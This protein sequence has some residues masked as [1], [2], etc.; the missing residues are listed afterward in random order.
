MMRSGTISDLPSIDAMNVFSGSRSEEIEEER[1][2][3]FELDSAVVGFIV[4][5]RKG[6]L[7]RP[8]IEYLAVS[9]EFRRCN[10]ASR[11]LEY[12]EAKH[13]KDR[14]F[15]STE[16]HNLPML[17]LLKDRGYIQAGVIAGANRNGADEIYFYREAV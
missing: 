13:A 5:S 17:E 6:L 4:E 2:H 16:A 8:L 11:L 15:I 7:G 9:Q 14:V 1:L 12:V 10:I 3:V